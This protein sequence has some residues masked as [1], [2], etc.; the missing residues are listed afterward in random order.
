[1]SH[2]SFARPN[3]TIRTYSRKMVKESTEIVK[4]IQQARPETSCKEPSMTQILNMDNS[5]FLDLDSDILEGEDNPKVFLKFH[6][7]VYFS[8]GSETK[9]SK[10]A[11]V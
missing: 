11:K 6:C 2:P 5:L 9:G 8:R 7:F 1:M 4:K 3:G 10:K